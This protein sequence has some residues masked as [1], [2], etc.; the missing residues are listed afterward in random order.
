MQKIYY[1]NQVPVESVVFTVVDET[2]RPRNLSAYTSASVIIVSPKGEQIAGGA[3]SITGSAQ[4]QVTY[5]FP[6]TSVFTMPGQYGIQLRLANGD[7]AD[8]ADV[9][10]IK[11]IEPLGGRA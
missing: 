6:G 11:V 10:Q 3:A 8:Y 7:R 4:G 1:V 9:L 5:T 2:R